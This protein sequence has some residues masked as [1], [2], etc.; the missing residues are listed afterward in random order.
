[1]CYDRGI[2]QAY[3]DGELSGSALDSVREH[4]AV[5]RACAAVLGELE[6][7]AAFVDSRL[8][9]LAGAVVFDADIAAAWKRFKEAKL[10]RRRRRIAS[11]FWGRRLA[12]VAAAVA[13]VLVFFAG[14]GSLDLFKMRDQAVEGLPGLTEQA[15]PVKKAPGGARGEKLPAGVRAVARPPHE[16]GAGEAPR[17]MVAAPP[18][19]MHVPLEIASVRE[20]WLRVPGEAPVSLTE[21]EKEQVVAWFNAGVPAGTVPE[22][23]ALESKPEGVSVAVYLTDGS[24]VVLLG[25]D[26]GEVTVRRLQGVYRLH[27]P[28]LAAYLKTKGGEVGEGIADR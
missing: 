2:L 3:L 17:A 26:A 15:S 25:A 10:R 28:E 7:N 1:M 8:R 9:E 14:V 24:E 5:C 27:A 4:V 23:Q 20:I 6:Q 22:D 11:V 18:A 16:E 19:E 21:A 12:A 13:L